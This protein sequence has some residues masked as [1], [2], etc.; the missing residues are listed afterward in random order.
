MSVPRPEYPRPQLRRSRWVNLNGPWSFAFDDDDRGLCERWFEATPT[1][2]TFPRT[3][4]V[5]FAF[6]SELSGIADRT[7]H[8][9]VWYS[10]SF[11]DARE[12][13]SDRLLLHFGAVDHE[14][15]VWVDGRQVTHHVG[16]HTPF[17]V[18]VTDALEHGTEHVVVVR[19]ADP[20]DDVTVPR[21]KQFW[22]ERPENIFYTATSGI[23]QTVWLEPVPAARI[24][25]L[26]ITPD[27]PEA[28]A[29]LTVQ[30]DP[31]A[32]GSTLR[33]VIRSDELTLVDDRISIREPEVTR[34]FGV[35][36]PRGSHTGAIAD[37]QDVAVWS[38]ETPHLHDLLLTL[39]HPDGRTVDDVESYFGMRSI[40]ARDGHVLLNGRPYYQR[41][42]LDQGYFPGGSLTAATD[43]DLRRDIELA[44]ELGF[45][46]ARKHQKV[47][48]PRWLYWADTL[49]FLVWDE[50]PSAYAFS[51][52]MA[53]RLVAEWQEVIARDR[54][55]PCVVA[56]VPMNESWGVPRLA[57]DRRH[58]DLVQALYHLTRSLDP[59]RLV[60]SNDG[61]EHG[62]TDV[63]T[64]HDYGTPDQLRANYANLETALRVQS[65][66][67]P[68]YH[69]G[70]GHRGEP[71][72][73][74]EFGGI[75]LVS[76]G[77]WG[78]HLVDSPELLLDRYREL[79]AA[80]TAS[81]VVRGFCY[82]QLTDVEQE[83]NGLLT[84]DREPKL[85]VA[86]VRAANQQPR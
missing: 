46:G 76:E 57:T 20:L 38:P 83:A 49:G 8:D 11:D 43:A 29:E 67:R 16:G 28:E 62:A 9:V 31:A 14:A 61:W 52:S 36:P 5:P 74:T 3:I 66:G 18:D 80:V 37:W 45:N 7:R 77:T 17:T 84:F 22:R 4:T 68:L 50:M 34:R 75:A 23:W 86:A 71:V 30:L 55:H 73:V 56:W 79:L 24:L 51:P 1:S 15:T 60:I 53:R 78:Y 70:H 12:S 54:N 82:T 40:E 26:T 35:A 47:E 6:Q 72:L 81:P 48:D 27:L 59:S 10:R 19:A 42:V 21:G 69:A 65:G 13:D 85:D 41:L 25:G 33:V 39:E 44:K 32:I 64:I 58:R 2:S 63:L